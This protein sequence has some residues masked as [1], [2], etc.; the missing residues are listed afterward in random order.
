MLLA[1]TRVPL[2]VFV[3]PCCVPPTNSLLSGVPL[4]SMF[5][6]NSISTG[7]PSTNRPAPLVRIETIV[8]PALSKT[9]AASVPDAVSRTITLFSLPLAPFSETKVW[10][11]GVATK[12]RGVIT[13]RTQPCKTPSAVPTSHCSALSP[14][15]PAVGAR[16]SAAEPVIVTVPAPSVKI[17]PVGSTVLTSASAVSSVARNCADAGFCARRA[18][19]SV[20]STSISAASKLKLSPSS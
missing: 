9:S 8:P 19:S 20:S 1:L 12:P 17:V 5:Q 6:L 10:F 16:N 13:T 18:R 2:D 11:V 15:G 4:A 7:V 3:E 14:S